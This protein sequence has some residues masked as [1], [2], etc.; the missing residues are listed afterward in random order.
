MG[1]NKCHLTREKL[2][3]VYL[4]NQNSNDVYDYISKADIITAEK[5]NLVEEIMEYYIDDNRE[6]I[7]EIINNYIYNK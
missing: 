7:G 4:P 6:K 2:I 3:S 1:L 5:D